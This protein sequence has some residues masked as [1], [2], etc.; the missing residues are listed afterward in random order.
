MKLTIKK[1]KQ[2]IKEEV[3]NVLLTENLSQNQNMEENLCAPA[4]RPQVG[5]GEKPTS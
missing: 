5:A 1:I 2:M 4:N 3:S